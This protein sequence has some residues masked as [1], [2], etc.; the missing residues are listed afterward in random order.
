[1]AAAMDGFAT[2]RENMVQTQVRPWGVT[3]LRIA[4]AMAEIPREAFLP[5]ALAPF[6]YSDAELSLET[7]ASGARRRLLRPLTLGLLLQAAEIGERDCVLNIG[8]PTGYSTAVLSR[9]AQ[10]VIAVERDEASVRAANEALERLGLA[11]AAT[12]RGR[13]AKGLEREAPFDVI[14]LNGRVNAPPAALLGQL[15]GGGRLVCVWG[16]ARTSVIRVWMRFGESLSWVDGPGAPAPPLE[17]PA[18]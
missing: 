11:N 4:L 3:D 18:A 8:C 12:V 9:I 14:I 7:D 16:E 1:M 10:S 5:E 15:A 13:P 2:A 6:A 17:E